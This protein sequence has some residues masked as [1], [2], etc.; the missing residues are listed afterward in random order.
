MLIQCDFDGTIIRNNLSV[1]LRENF[2]RVGWREIEAAYIQR[3]LT[4]EESNRQ[5][6]RLIQESRK[7]LQEFVCQHIE[8]RPGFVEFINYCRQQSIPFV[9][10]SSGVDFYIEA[11]LARIGM[12][13]LECYCG[14]GVF[15]EDGIA[16]RYISPE[17][18]LLDSGFKH[19]YL[20][21]LRQRDSTIIYLGDGYSDIEPARQAEHVLAT[22][23]LPDLLK[24]ES[25]TATSFDDFYDV[26]SEVNRLSQ[27]C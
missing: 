7:K 1:L 17:G 3:S 2:A 4:V 16:V 5:Q 21:W 27:Q 26:I 6:Y 25:I 22:G 13:H 8:L 24:A 18:N 14:Q 10:V 9:I 19:R 20:A 12:S 11:V 23:M 15:T